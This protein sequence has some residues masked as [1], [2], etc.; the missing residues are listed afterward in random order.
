MLGFPGTD[1]YTP[2]SASVYFNRTDVQDAIHA[3][4]TDWAE[5]SPLSIYN[6]SSGVSLEYNAGIFSSMTVLPGVIERSKRTL[7][8]HG[9]LDYILMRNG[10]LLSIQNLTW[11]GMQ[12]FQAPIQDDFYVPY[13][14]S[15]QPSTMA[16]AGVMG[17]TR[18]E[19]GLTFF[20][21]D[22]SGHMIPQY[23]PSAAYRSLEVLL[24]RVE[25]LTSNETFTTSSDGLVAQQPVV[26]E[27]I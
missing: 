9:G 15:F 10:T 12:G 22:L 5:A 2:T 18:T 20:S 26:F 25:S 14:A 23:A 3:P 8:G 27:S 13:R 11:N 24:G 4:H 16:G 7:I 19:R 17:K 6:T 21:V 1:Q